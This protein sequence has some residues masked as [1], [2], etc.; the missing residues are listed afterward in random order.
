ME[1]SRLALGRAEAR[2]FRIRGMLFVQRSGWIEGVR[3]NSVAHFV[4]EKVAVAAISAVLLAELAVVLNL[5]Q[6]RRVSWWKRVAL[7][8]HDGGRIGLFGR[9]V[10]AGPCPMDADREQCSD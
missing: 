1:C 2:H 7:E 6:N 5:V 10:R 4:A 9:R 8:F 3:R